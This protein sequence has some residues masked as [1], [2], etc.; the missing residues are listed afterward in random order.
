MFLS[1]QGENDFYEHNIDWSMPTPHYLNFTSWIETIE[2]N[3]TLLCDLAPTIRNIMSEAFDPQIPST[4]AT[5]RDQL[6]KRHA[7]QAITSEENSGGEPTHD[8]R[9]M[10]T[11]R[12]NFKK[13]Y[14][15]LRSSLRTLSNVA[16]S[17]GAVTTRPASAKVIEP[18]PT[19]H[20]F[21]S[22]RAEENWTGRPGT[23]ELDC[24]L[25]A[26]VA[27]SRINPPHS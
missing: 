7:I 15:R 27:S 19:D 21:G 20:T 22:M 23:G 11:W 3:V 17:P 4:L 9:P 13:S 1:E 6:A 10:A 8:P 18:Y 24:C 2:E 25:V 12:P 26:L 16:K 14:N 5:S